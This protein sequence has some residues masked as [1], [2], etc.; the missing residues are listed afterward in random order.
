[1]Q[2]IGFNFAKI[3]ADR[4]PLLEPSLDIKTNIEFFN[5][6]KEK[7]SLLKD[8]EPIKISFKF[9]INYVKKEE[10]KETEEA[11]I[12][13]EGYLIL[14]ASSEESKE[15]FKEWK[16]K[17]IPQGIRL[18]LFNIILK[19]CSVRALQLEEE[20]NLPIHIPI[21]QIQPIQPNHQK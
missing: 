10:K 20:L 3:Q 19:R 12:T 16:K 14:A 15:I 21:P 4:K 13:F 5:I 2:V 7:V 11:K 6:E 18:P 1:M 8:L 17:Q 9:S